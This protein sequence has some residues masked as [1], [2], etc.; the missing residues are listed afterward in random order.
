MK[1]WI[2]GEGLEHRYFTQTVL[3]YSYG[4]SVL[5]Y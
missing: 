3:H 5:K 2:W 4:S 1:A